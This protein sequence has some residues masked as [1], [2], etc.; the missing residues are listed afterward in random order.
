MKR[1]EYVAKHKEEYIDLYN[2]KLKDYGIKV[3][4][5]SN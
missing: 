3:M 5:I 1:D 4:F 2:E